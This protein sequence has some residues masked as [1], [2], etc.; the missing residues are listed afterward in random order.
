MISPSTAFLRTCEETC[1][2]A[3]LQLCLSQLGG[4]G[5]LLRCL[6]ELSP[7]LSCSL[8]PALEVA[9]GCPVCKCIPGLCLGMP[10]LQCLL[11]RSL[12]TQSLNH[13]LFASYFSCYTC[14]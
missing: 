13:V 10:L 6:L 2:I 4:L 5:L 12:K 7:L 9:Q 1:F 3:Y 11:P 8:Q 14:S